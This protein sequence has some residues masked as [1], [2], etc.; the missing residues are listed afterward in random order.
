MDG[1]ES[2][3]RLYAPFL[4][5]YGA[6]IV[7][8]AAVCFLLAY[9]L[10]RRAKSGTFYV[11]RTTDDAQDDDDNSHPSSHEYDDDAEHIPYR[12]DVYP[13][14]EM[15]ARSEAFHMMMQKRRTVR[16]FT[17]RPIPRTI[18]ENVL[19]AAGASPSGAN[20]QPWTYVVVSN[21]ATKAEIRDIIE[22]EERINYERRMGDAWV[23]ELRILK[24]SWR[25]PHLETAPYVI[26]V[27]RQLYG[28]RSDG[29]RKNYYYTDISVAI[30]V[31][32]LLAG[33]Q[34]V[35][36]VTTTTTPLNAGPALRKLL[37][38]PANE[39]VML[40]LPVGYAAEDA[41]VPPLRRK[42]LDEQFLW[43]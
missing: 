24:T 38:R 43:V 15:I 30:S 25:K 26:V 36:L 23:K 11:E 18:I 41:T 13:Q 10:N 28:V 5:S 42:S 2:T 39:R 1:I 8:T 22:A 27:L 21:P 40:L 12:A 34:N 3:L 32:I 37:Q 9:L 6:V 20:S 33:L 17:D 29:S 19:Y 14:E 35:G 4:V 16:F 7:P 31:G